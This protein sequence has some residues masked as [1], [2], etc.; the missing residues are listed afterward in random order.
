MTLTADSI[1]LIDS[2][3]GLVVLAIKAAHS[4]SRNTAGSTTT[5]NSIAAILLNIG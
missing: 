2:L 1:A 5:I 3:V 4:C